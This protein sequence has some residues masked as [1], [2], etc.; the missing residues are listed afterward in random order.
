MKSASTTCDAIQNWDKSSSRKSLSAD[1]KTLTALT[2]NSLMVQAPA[3][4]L[5]FKLV[6]FP[7]QNPKLVL[8]RVFP[9]T[10]QPTI[11]QSIPNGCYNFPDIACVITT[12]NF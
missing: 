12:E 9:K 5:D 2:N 11:L 7:I 1:E 3:P 4:I 8:R 6:N 10:T